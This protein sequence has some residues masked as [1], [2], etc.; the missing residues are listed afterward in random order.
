MRRQRH[1]RDTTCRA[2]RGAFSLVELTMCMAIM[3]ILAGIAMP[4]YAQSI[5]SYRARAAAQ[6]LANDLAQV[7]SYARTSSSSQ[8]IS[9][10]A[11]NSTYQISGLR[12]LESSSSTYLV[13]LGNEPYRASIATLSLGGAT[14]IVF[15]GYGNPNRGGSITL[16]SG[17]TTRT[18]VIDASSGKVLVQ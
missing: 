10:N 4:R 7:Q 17:T 13:S 9:F 3:A 16:Q 2:T 15:N 8:T 14:N 18:V 5:A 11:T 1:R 6:R 12:D